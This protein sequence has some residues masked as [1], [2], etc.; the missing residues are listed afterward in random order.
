MLILFLPVGLSGQLSRVDSLRQELTQ[1]K[2]D[3]T[4]ILLNNKI[5]RE[6]SEENKDS[7][8]LIL[9]S[10]ISNAEKINHKEGLFEL[11]FTKCLIC[12]DYDNYDSALAAIETAHG[13]AKELE[14][15]KRRVQSL[16]ELANVYNSTNKK[17]TGHQVLEEALELAPIW[18]I[19]NCCL[20]Y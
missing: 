5:A 18:T 14:D 7:A 2:E 11:Y 16:L 9:E 4:R 13:I 19:R 1:T 15:K 8:L 3:S 6:L 20:T 10:A 17:K 12:L